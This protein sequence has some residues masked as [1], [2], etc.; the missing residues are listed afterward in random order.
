MGRSLNIKSISGK[1]GKEV[2]GNVRIKTISLKLIST[3]EE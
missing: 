2:I 3:L 1:M